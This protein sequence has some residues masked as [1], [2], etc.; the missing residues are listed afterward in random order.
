MSVEARNVRVIDLISLNGR[1]KDIPS[2]QEALMDEDYVDPFLHKLAYFLNRI[3]DPLKLNLFLKDQTDKMN[4][5][6]LWHIQ[7][8]L[9]DKGIMYDMQTRREWVEVTTIKKATKMKNNFGK[10]IGILQIGR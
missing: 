7:R 8:A 3:K 6:K 1:Y 10:E 4:C 9:D 2:I 5:P